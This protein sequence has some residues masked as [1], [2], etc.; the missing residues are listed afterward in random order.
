MEKDLSPTLKNHY[1]NLGLSNMKYRNDEINET[2]TIQPVIGK[3]MG[4]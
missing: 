2:L 3:G 1:D 4:Y